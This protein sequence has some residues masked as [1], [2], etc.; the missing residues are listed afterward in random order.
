MQY[1]WKSLLNWIVL[2]MERYVFSFQICLRSD[3]ERKKLKGDN[4]SAIKMKRRYFSLQYIERMSPWLDNKFR[5]TLS[6]EDSYSPCHCTPR[7]LTVMNLI[8]IQK[9]QKTWKL[10]YSYKWYNYCNIRFIF[11]LFKIVSILK[12]PNNIPYSQ[13]KFISNLF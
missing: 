13:L 8:T 2:Y 10:K 12:R 9:R 3:S 5:R 6:A 7:I 4:R 1:T 11:S